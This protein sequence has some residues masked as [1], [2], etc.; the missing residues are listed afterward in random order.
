MRRAAPDRTGAP[1]G[2]TLIE[3]LITVAIVALLASVALPLSQIS[4]TRSKE[5]ELRHALREVRSAI[6]AYKQAADDGRIARSADESGY[7]KTL[8]ALAQGVEDKRSGKAGT[9]IYFLR[10]VPRDPFAED[11]SLAA[12][13]TWGKRSYA[14]P[15]DDPRE[16]A[17]VFDVYSLSKRTGLNGI[18]YREW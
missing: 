2:F 4:A 13:D 3:L 12:A 16:G 10:R 14:S 5:V 15:P 1:A 8:E 17:D 6:D 7:P 9:M 18:P 11:P